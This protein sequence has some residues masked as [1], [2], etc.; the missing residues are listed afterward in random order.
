MMVGE[1]FLLDTKMVATYYGTND[2]LHLSF[3]FPPL[4]TPWEASR[5]RKQIEITAS[6]LDPDRRVADVGAVE[7]RQPSAP[8]SVR[9]PRRPGA[10]RHR[11]AGRVAGHTLPVRR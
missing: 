3:N 4:F 1:V 10:R 7:P 5:W 2:E 8:K 11:V 6:E 9:R